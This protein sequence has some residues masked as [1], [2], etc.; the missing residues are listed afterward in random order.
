LLAESGDTDGRVKMR[1]G[2]L[3]GTA[4]AAVGVYALMW[5]GYTQNWAW[6]A[7]MDAS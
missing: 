3:I 2:W 4:L 7:R 6:L 5:L 1:L